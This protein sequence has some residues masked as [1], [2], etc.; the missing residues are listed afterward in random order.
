MIIAK[1]RVREIMSPP[2]IVLGIT[3]KGMSLTKNK[4]RFQKPLISSATVKAHREKNG[5]FFLCIFIL[6]SMEGGGFHT[7]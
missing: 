3:W 5:I 6:I 4:T 2:F 1:K 7:P